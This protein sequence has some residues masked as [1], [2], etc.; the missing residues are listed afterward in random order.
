MTGRG[1]AA[2]SG[3]RTAPVVDLGT[4]SLGSSL[5]KVDSLL[6]R[7]TWTSVAE[8]EQRVA[9]AVWAGLSV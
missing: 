4:A 5:R 3:V 8:A 1:R 9:R 7:W 6:G 2:P